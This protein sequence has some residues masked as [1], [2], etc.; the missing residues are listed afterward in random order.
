MARQPFIA[1]FETDQFMDEFTA[2]LNN[3]QDRAQQLQARRAQARSYRR[4]LPGETT[5]PAPPHLK[6]YQ[7]AHGHFYLIT[8]ALVCQQMGLPDRAINPGAQERA[9]FVLR[10]LA[11]IDHVEYE[12][13]WVEVSGTKQWVN[14][15]TEGCRELAPGEITYPL[16]P[17]NYRERDGRT[18][19]V[20]AGLIPTSSRE[21]ATATAISASNPLFAD[22]ETVAGARID[23]RMTEFEVRLKLPLAALLPAVVAPSGTSALDRQREATFF[24]LL[25]LGELLSLHHPTVWTAVNDGPDPTGTA[26]NL[27]KWLKDTQANGVSVLDMLK[28]AWNNER[29]KLYAEPPQ[30]I[31]IT[32]NFAGLGAGHA[33]STLE[34]VWNPA[35]PAT[36]PTPPAALSG[37]LQV[38]LAAPKIDAVSRYVIRCVYQRPLCGCLQPDIVSERT[39]MFKIAPFFDPDAPARPIRITMP[40]DTSIAGLRKYTR[41]VGIE[42]SKE[43]RRQISRVADAKKALDGELSGELQLDLGVIC[44]FS[45]P[46]IT[47]VALLLLMIFV[48]LLNIVFWWLPF[49]RICFP[50]KR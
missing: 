11:T 46:I 21:T 42:M 16:F 32:Y 27:F 14:C 1:R 45:I 9:I 25:D 39:D 10:R 26:L 35:L 37:E 34:S 33:L 28:N 8:A 36:A 20:L 22:A 40:A 48:I 50:I 3:A 18:R 29:P 47:I 23:P 15:P 41:S 38:A 24:W 43:L 2:L 7:P 12:Q 4:L 31:N 17:I 49:F 13:A 30:T 19:R 5:V 6:L 44:S